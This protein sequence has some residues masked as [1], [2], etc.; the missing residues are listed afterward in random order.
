MWIALIITWAFS[1]G[2]LLDPTGPDKM[3]HLNMKSF[4][5]REQYRKHD[6]GGPQHWKGRESKG[7][8]EVDTYLAMLP[9]AAPSVS[10]PGPV[11]QLATE[12]PRTTYGPPTGI[13]QNHTNVGPILELSVQAI[14]NLVEAL[15]QFRGSAA[16]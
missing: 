3:G 4:G 5:D 8:S 15:P 12:L 1:C 6:E 10:Q 14:C 13:L 7:L 16:A 11:L 9:R 2:F